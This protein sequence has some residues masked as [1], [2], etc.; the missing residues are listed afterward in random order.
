MKENSL[1]SIKKD[2]QLIKQCW[3][4]VKTITYTTSSMLNPIWL[5]IK[6]KKILEYLISKKL[7]KYQIRTKYWIKIGIRFDLIAVFSK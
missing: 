5:D 6:V 7:N 1:K 4:T 2:Q 3:K